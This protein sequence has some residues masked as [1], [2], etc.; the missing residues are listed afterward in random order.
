[1]SDGPLML[2]PRVSLDA[3]T[4]IG[5]SGSLV[6]RRAPAALA[7][8][9]RAAKTARAC[10]TNTE[11]LRMSD[12][13]LF[14]RHRVIPFPSGPIVAT[15]PDFGARPTLPTL[16]RWWPLS[17]LRQQKCAIDPTGIAEKR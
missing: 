1:M 5:F 10:R 11:I 7:A 17:A 9:A 12:T 2:S 14:R 16:T 8:V 15:D 13:S 4:T 6:A 3:G